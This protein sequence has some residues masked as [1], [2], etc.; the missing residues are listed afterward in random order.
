LETPFLSEGVAALCRER[1]SNKEPIRELARR[2]GVPNVPKRP[3]LFP[4]PSG[5]DVVAHTT[6]LLIDYLQRGRVQ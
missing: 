1:R 3:T 5:I 4:P 2:Y 6:E